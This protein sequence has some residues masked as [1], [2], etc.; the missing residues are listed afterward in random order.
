MSSSSRS[1]ARPGS[2]RN[3]KGE[4]RFVEEHVEIEED[5]EEVVWVSEEAANQGWANS[6]K[7]WGF[8]RKHI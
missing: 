8:L 2:V 5:E 3:C 6:L 1:I 7:C 4:E